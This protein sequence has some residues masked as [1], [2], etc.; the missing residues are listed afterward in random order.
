M[1]ITYTISPTMLPNQQNPFES[2]SK[3]DPSSKTVDQQP[4]LANKSMAMAMA[5]PLQASVPAPIQGDGVLPHPLQR[6]ISDVQSTECPIMSDA[7]NQQEDLMIEGGT[8]S[9]TSAYSQG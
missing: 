6:P 9:I 3:K 7:L 1:R 2:D 4:E 8:I 5:I